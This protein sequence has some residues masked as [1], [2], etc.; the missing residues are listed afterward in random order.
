MQLWENEMQ[1]EIRRYREL[2]STNLEAKRLAAELAEGLVVVAD[3]QSDGRGRRGRSWE[4]P[5]GNLYFS[6]LLK[7][8]IRVE[9][10]SMLTLV[11]AY[12]V[13][14]YLKTLCEDIWIKWPNDIVSDGKKICGI[15]TEMDVCDGR[16]GSVIIGVGINRIK[17]CIPESLK[18]TATALEEISD[19]NP[20]R[21]EMIRGI[22][23]YFQQNYMQFLREQDLS[24]LQEKYN[25][26]L[27]N[28]N[29]EVRVLEPGNEYLALAKG[30][31][32]R[33][34]LLVRPE[35]GEERAI[36]AGEVSVRG[37]FGYV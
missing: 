14:E 24:G 17:A 4:S 11:M 34:E 36:Y 6:V 33:G 5:M 19:Q 35:N 21:E 31:N 28:A 8:D 2:D 23:A 3:R 32:N 7:P 25:R 10:A 15:L 13:A 9:N 18:E 27:I 12:S 26:L 30:I 16:I 1:W 22:L 20:E 37:C 29:R